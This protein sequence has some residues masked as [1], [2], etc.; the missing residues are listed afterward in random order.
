MVTLSSI[1][2]RYGSLVAVDAVSFTI[3][4]GEFFALLGP[5][6]AGKTTTVKMILDFVRP[7]SGSITIDGISSK[8]PLSRARVGYCGE[9]HRI[10]AHLT[11]K[12][13][14][15][16]LASLAG[17]NKK[18]ADEKIRSL[19]EIVGMTGKETME[20][21]TYSKGMMQRIALAGALVTDPKLLVLD[22]PTSG[23]DPIGIREVRNILEGLRAKGVTVILNS[24]LLSEVEKICDT[25]AIM[26]NGRILVKDRLSAI[27]TGAETLE[28]VFVRLVKDSHA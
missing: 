7:S 18:E 21:H 6:G 8:S 11:G 27:T 12:G 5:N 26:K 24:H 28:D 16:R 2:K 10:P 25:A 17:M 22:E 9:N 20:A 19:M 3:N 4:K 14:C 1:T 13:Y 15:R 23:L